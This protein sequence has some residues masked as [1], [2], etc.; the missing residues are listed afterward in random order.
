MAPFAV[1]AG[2][3]EEVLKTWRHESKPNFERNLMEL[4][5]EWN[6]ENQ[7]PS[8]EEKDKYPH[9]DVDDFC[10]RARLDRIERKLHILGETLLATKRKNP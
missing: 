3:I 5:N 10:S 6:E 9:L 1:A 8:Y 4:K 7:K 2:L